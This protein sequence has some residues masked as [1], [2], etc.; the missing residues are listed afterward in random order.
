MFSNQITTS[1]KSIFIKLKYATMGPISYAL[2]EAQKRLNEK[3]K[4]VL[5]LPSKDPN[6][7]KLPSG[8]LV[9]LIL[10]HENQKRGK[11]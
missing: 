4:L 11:Y 6:Y 10:K 1:L 7:I 9:E 3:R 2:I 8:G 5:V